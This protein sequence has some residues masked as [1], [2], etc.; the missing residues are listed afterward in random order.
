MFL[1]LLI[2]ALSGPAAWA[3][4]DDT[5]DALDRLGEI[6]ELRIEDGTLPK[7]KVSPAILVSATPRYE[8]TAAWFGTGAVQRGPGPHPCRQSAR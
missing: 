6:L 8:E 2:V 7:A 3:G 1:S 4:P 5:R